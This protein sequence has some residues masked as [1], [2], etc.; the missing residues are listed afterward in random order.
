[1]PE[2]TLK[3]LTK[4]FNGIDAVKSLDLV[5]EEKAF[6][7]IVGPSGCG[8]TTTLR[9]I[10]GLE[11]ITS[12][13]IYLDGQKINE[14]P[15]KDRD[16]AMVFQDYAI[17][18]HMSV[19]DN[20]GFG[21]RMHKM[22]K[23]D[24]AQRVGEAAE[25]LAISHL[26]TRRPHELSGGER[27]RVALG[28]A[29]V[30]RPKIFL[31]DEPLANLD[32]ALRTQMRRELSRLHKELATTFIYV[33]HDQIEA[34]TMATRIAI[35]DHG[36]LQQSDTPM[37]IYHS[38]AN[39]FVAGFIGNP[40]MNLLNCYFETRQGELYLYLGE[41]EITV[42]NAVREALFEKRLIG[43]T[44]LLGIRPEYIYFITTQDEN[45]LR[46]EIQFTENT[47]TD[48]F[49]FLRVPGCENNIIARGDLE[50]TYDYHQ[51]GF[52]FDW[53]HVRLFDS[54]GLPALSF[55]ET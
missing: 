47:G 51:I 52:D 35:L 8:K 42:P 30:R 53:K 4:T 21:L 49:V 41:Q 1:M 37:K 23:P 10:A 9:L 15:P 46:A 19:F 3:G 43:K 32:A 40:K 50:Q 24:I 36:V 45:R 20:I 11:E 5:I 18:P 14:T 34:M 6:M 31:F 39:S 7:V 26:L 29:I 38:P 55:A 17:Y 27:Q 22:S 54:N 48:I 33:T 12:G 28:R 25:L 2:L 13:E 16:M 44:L